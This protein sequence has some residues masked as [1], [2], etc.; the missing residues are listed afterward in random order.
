MRDYLLNVDND[1]QIVDGNF[2]K[3]ESSLQNQKLLL[4][5]EKGAFKQFP[6]TC[7]GLSSYLMD[8]NPN[9]MLREIRLQFAD[10]GMK[11]KGIS[12]ANG[13]LNIDAPY[14]N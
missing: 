1:L 2:L 10:D 8:D 11:V 7:V 3:G 9:G 6:T 14:G 4:M 13:V 12:Y 5:C